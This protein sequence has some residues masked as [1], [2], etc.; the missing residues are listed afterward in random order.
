MWLRGRKGTP[1]PSPSLGSLFLVLHPL[2]QHLVGLLETERARDLQLLLAAPGPVRLGVA[3][4]ARAAMG[5]G[6]GCQGV[7]AGP[8]QEQLQAVGADGRQRPG[9]GDAE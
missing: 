9:G 1:P 4:G 6:P 5:A 2:L 8:R 7:D 3:V